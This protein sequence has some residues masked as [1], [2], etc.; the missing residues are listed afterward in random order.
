MLLATQIGPEAKITQADH[1]IHGC[2]D[3]V[4]HV[5]QEISLG[6]GSVIGHI[7]GGFQLCLKVFT[8]GDVMTNG[9]YFL[10]A[11]IF[12]ND[13]VVGPTHP[14]F[15][16]VT[17]AILTFQAEIFLGI[18]NNIFYQVRNSITGFHAIPDDGAEQGFTAQLFFRETKQVHAIGVY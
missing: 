14:Q 9:Q 5:G 8:L 16:T 18:R 4:T 1:G 7:H 12:I 17:I 15:F 6:L 11:A 13:R 3:F 10:Q 2:S